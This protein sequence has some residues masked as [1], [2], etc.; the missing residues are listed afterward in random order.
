MGRLNGCAYI[1]GDPKADPIA[2]CGRPALAGK[3][4]CAEHWDMTHIPLLSLDELTEIQRM[5]AIA[6]AAFIPAGLE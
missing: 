3:P 6:K 1:H 5:R 2:W 4:Y